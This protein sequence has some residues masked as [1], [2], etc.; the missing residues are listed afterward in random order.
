MAET[1]SPAKG[2]FPFLG[3]VG[4]YDVFLGIKCVFDEVSDSQRQGNLLLGGQASDAVIQRLFQHYVYPW[5]F[6]RHYF[7]LS[8]SVAL[9]QHP[10][11]D[12]SQSRIRNGLFD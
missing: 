12:E 1:A 8:K 3:D 10:C 7:S 4:E 9:V 11:K 2:L 6:C 5:I